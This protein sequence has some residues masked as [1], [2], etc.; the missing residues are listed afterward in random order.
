M[1]NP[2]TPSPTTIAKV[3]KE[4]IEA[5]ADARAG[6]TDLRNRLESAAARETRKAGLAARAYER[7]MDE[8]IL[9]DA[10]SHALADALVPIFAGL[11]LGYFAG[12][13]RVMDNQNVRTLITFVMSFAVPAAAFP[14]DCPAR[15]RPR[16]RGANRHRIGHHRRLCG[17][18]R[19]RL[20]F[21]SASRTVRERPIA[22]SSRIDDQFPGRRLSVYRCS[23]LPS[24]PGAT[25]RCCRVHRDWLNYNLAVDSGSSGSRSE[26]HG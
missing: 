26:R 23:R 24:D 2:D 1:Q 25:V 18:V 17:P 11:L 14:S 10:M 21:C 19:T 16:A 13:W 12:L 22:L 5:I 4:L 3:Q 20:L 7:R 8:V 15:R 6:A 9:Q